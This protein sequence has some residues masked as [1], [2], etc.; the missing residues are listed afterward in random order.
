[1]KSLLLYLS[2]SGPL[3]YRLRDD[4]ITVRDAD[5]F[6]NHNVIA[7]TINLIN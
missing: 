4:N 7:G 3:H 2:S 1:M 5:S 6:K